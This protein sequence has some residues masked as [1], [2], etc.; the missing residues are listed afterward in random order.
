MPV[1]VGGSDIKH[2]GILKMPNCEELESIQIRFRNYQIAESTDDRTKAILN[3]KSLMTSTDYRFPSTLARATAFVRNICGEATS[4]SLLSAIELWNQLASQL[5]TESLD[6]LLF[7]TVDALAFAIEWWCGLETDDTE[8]D[9]EPTGDER[10]DRAILN[11]VS[12]KRPINVTVDAA[13]ASSNI[14][15]SNCRWSDAVACL[16]G[17]QVVL[18]NAIKKSESG[19]SYKEIIDIEGAFVDTA[20]IESNARTSITRIRKAWKTSGVPFEIPK[21]KRNGKLRVISIKT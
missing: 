7:E 12:R 4:D 14:N 9:Y 11:L 3:I 2:Y 19:L 15:E 6:H 17:E 10:A 5:H 1:A 13:K 16:T 8:Y 18:V 20:P 21:P